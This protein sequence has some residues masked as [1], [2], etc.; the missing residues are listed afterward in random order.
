LNGST[1]RVD[2]DPI[3]AALTQILKSRAAIEQAKGVL[4]VLYNIDADAA[5]DVLKGRS[6]HG[7][8][9]LRVLAEQL[10]TDFRLLY[11]GQL[12]LPDSTFDKI[13]LTADESLTAAVRDNDI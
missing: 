13:S 2:V 12:G 7:H 1:E 5:F 4:M 8:V 10:M 3:S 9:K 6:Q 11:W